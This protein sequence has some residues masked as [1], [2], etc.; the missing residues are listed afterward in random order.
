MTWV[1]SSAG[2]SMSELIGLGASDGESRWI[3]V[4]RHQAVLV[5]IGAGLIGGWFTQSRG[6][7]IELLVGVGFVTC[8]APSAEGLTI[9]E[10]VRIAQSYAVRSRWTT[11]RIS[12]GIGTIVVAAR[13]AASSRGFELQ[14]R[15]RLDLSGRDRQN[16]VALSEFADALAASDETR[17]FSLHVRS[18]GGD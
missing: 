15:G 17:H 9:A 7:L 14:H 5:I 16:A 3:G 18:S 12:K 2:T 13:G 10:R 1:P 11:V 6:P 8:V 4:R